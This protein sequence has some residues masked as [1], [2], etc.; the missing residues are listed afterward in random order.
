MKAVLTG[1]TGTNKGKTSSADVMEK[2]AVDPRVKSK[3]ERCVKRK[4]RALLTVLGPSA[5]DQVMILH[6]LLTKAAGERHSVLWC[7]KKDSDIPRHS[8]KHLKKLEKNISS[9]KCDISKENAFDLFLLSTPVKYC[10]F[11][12]SHRLL[13]NT[14]GMCVIQDFEGLTPNILCRVVETVCGGGLVVFLMPEVQSLR[15][16]FSAPMD[17]HS[18]LKTYSHPKVTPLFNERFVLSLGWCKSCLV[19]NDQLQVTSEL[20]A[21][22]RPPLLPNSLPLHGTEASQTKLKELRTSLE[23]ADKPLPQLVSCCRTFDQAQALLKMIDLITEKSVQGTVA[24]TAGRG[25]GKSAALGL[26][27]AA[28]IHVGLNNIFVTSPT[29][30]NLGTFFEFVFKGFDALE[31][32]EQ[33][34]YE[35]IQSTNSEFGDAVV[36]INVFRDYRQTVQYISP[37][38]AGK[39][40][41]AELVVV[42]EAAAIP[43]PQVKALIGSCNAIMSSTINGYEGTGRSLS[44]KLL[45]QLRVQAGQGGTAVVAS[46]NAV[47]GAPTR[48]SLHEVTLEESVRYASHDPVEA[49]LHQL[50][51]LD[52]TSVIAP[53]T[54]CPP[55]HTCQLY[56]VNR[57]V[58]FSGHS[59]SEAFLQQMVALLVAS[60]YR[61]SPDDL[62]VL[63]DAP[64]HHLFVLLPPLPPGSAATLPTVL[65]VIQVCMEGG[66]P[67]SV[68]KATRSRGERPSG[69]LVP[70]LLSAQFLQPDLTQLKGV[71]VVRVATHP[72][73]QSMGYGS[74]AISL[75]TDYYGGKHLALDDPAVTIPQP[76]Q[77]PTTDKDSIVPRHSSKPLL[78]ALGER[79][80]EAVDYLGVSYGVTLPL[81]KFWCRAAYVPLYISQVAN[82]VTGEHS[83]VMVH[84]LSSP[85][86][87]SDSEIAPSWLQDASFEFLRRFLSLLGGPLNDL[88]PM[89]SLAVI[90]A[91]AKTVPWKAI[92]WE[93][94]KTL[95]TGHDLL[96]LEKYSKNLADRHLITDIL[97]HI[98]SL[99]FSHRFPALH[100]S[101]IQSA[102]M[103]GLGLQ[104]KNFDE[105]SQLLDLPVESVLG[106]FN[107][108]V[109]RVLKTMTALQEEALTKHLPKT[110]KKL[111][112]FVPVSI[113][114]DQDL[115]E[116]AEDY[117]EKEKKRQK[118]LPQAS[119][120][121]GDISKFA[122]KSDEAAWQAALKGGSNTVISVKSNKRPAAITEK[123]LEME[124]EEPKQKKKKKSTKGS[125]KEKS[126]KKL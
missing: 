75:L 42:D 82:K 106:Q 105:V 78:S 70:W 36:R 123:E 100:L 12:D 48:R 43:L 51:C 14:F 116:A 44:L 72:D 66:I 18:R 67:A 104:L 117:E 13:G 8:R 6:H 23:D 26:A 61:N 124:L 88:H 102:L 125:K 64:A 33:N 113:S 53:S 34:D 115:E 54:T 96:R 101:P 69:D 76:T 2:V 111:A 55:P 90:Q 71:R 112:E 39:L 74:R 98:A 57:E 91:H 1:N 110:T 89:L 37:G 65:A 58:L 122:I 95:V 30:E 31:Y 87:T 92:E 68:S 99:F 119:E 126:S 40:S 16:L 46:T 24:V 114:L 10:S 86:E 108:A 21:L 41:H 80:P 93:E 29:P 49:W 73:Y 97:P 62:Q 25:R 17:V 107:R 20:P 50:L 94:L 7:H 103:V 9:G 22:S 5:R 59:E 4:H 3:V 77:D 11:Q 120:L 27:T 84:V 52:A 32:E 79:P 118:L 19:L 38:D 85:E 63:C 83:C 109:R 15:Q 35:I 47:D 121:L 28:A 56:Y 81:L 60:H 45:Q